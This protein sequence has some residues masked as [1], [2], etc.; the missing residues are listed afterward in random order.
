MTTLKP[1]YMEHIKNQ[2]NQLKICS[3]PNNYYNHKLRSSI[4]MQA[5]CI[6]KLCIH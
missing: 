6:G 3:S 5:Q 2:Q 4:I 1:D